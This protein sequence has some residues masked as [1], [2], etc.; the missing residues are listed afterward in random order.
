MSPWHLR[1]PPTGRV[2]GREKKLASGPGNEQ[3]LAAMKAKPAPLKTKHPEM[4]TFV[5]QIRCL[6]CDFVAP[7]HKP[8]VRL[9][10]TGR[11][12]ICGRCSGCK[13]IRF[14]VIEKVASP[15]PD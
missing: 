15:P 9:N 8:G 11:K 5:L 4:D 6:R 1:S 10:A 12:I 7:W 14:L 2:D 3:K 13:R